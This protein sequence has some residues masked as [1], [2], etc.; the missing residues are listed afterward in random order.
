MMNT[1]LLVRFIV[2]Y[3]LYVNINDSHAQEPQLNTLYVPIGKLYPRSDFAGV[4]IDLNVAQAIDR[5]KLALNIT[6]ILIIIDQNKQLE[7]GQ[8]KIGLFIS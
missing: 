8:E 3:A 5:G 1:K 7:N 4:L 2:V 6:L